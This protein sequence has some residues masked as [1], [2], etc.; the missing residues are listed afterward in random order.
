MPGYSS[1]IK[2]TKKIVQLAF[3]EQVSDKRLPGI[4]NI[5]QLLKPENLTTIAVRVVHAL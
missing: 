4:A 3:D 2:S 1:T 5:I